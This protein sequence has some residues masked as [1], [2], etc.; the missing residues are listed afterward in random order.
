MRDAG[1]GRIVMATSSSGLYGNFGQANY[2]AAKLGLVGLMQTLG[3]EGEKHNIHVNAVAPVAYTDMTVDLFP[4]GAD[5]LMAPEMVAPGVVFLA[6]E[7]APNKAILAAGGGAYAVTH[8]METAGAMLGAQADAD[9][10]AARYAEISD[11]A[12]T[13]VIGTGPTQTM[14]HFALVSKQAV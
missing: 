8:I 5:T 2:S 1:Y 14:K 7:G 13:Q 4:Q 12:A 9:M 10:L 11:P 6:S 3:I